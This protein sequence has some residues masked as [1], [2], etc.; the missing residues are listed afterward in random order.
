MNLF[1]LNI[2]MGVVVVVLFLSGNIGIALIA[3]LVFAIVAL[4]LGRPKT[5]APPDRGAGGGGYS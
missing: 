2:V 4:R 3:L 5:P 1:L